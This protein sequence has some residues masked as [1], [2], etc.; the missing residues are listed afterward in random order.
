V[1]V[2]GVEHRVFFGRQ[3]FRSVCSKKIWVVSV[4]WDSLI[5]NSLCDFFI[6]TKFLLWVF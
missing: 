4:D 3:K 1:D 5:K 6:T 2:L